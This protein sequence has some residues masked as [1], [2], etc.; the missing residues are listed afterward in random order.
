MT[1]EN[2]CISRLSL[3]ILPAGM[4]VWLFSV[5]GNDENFYLELP[6]MGFTGCTFIL[7][8]IS[9]EPILLV[10]DFCFWV[11]HPQLCLFILYLYLVRS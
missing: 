8:A 10:N 1:I 9:F 3:R 5:I 11:D 6:T 7:L 4:F 2:H